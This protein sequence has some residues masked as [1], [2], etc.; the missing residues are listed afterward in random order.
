MWFESSVRWRARLTLRALRA[1][2]RDVRRA[3]DRWLLRHVSEN[4]RSQFGLAHQFA[5][6]GSAADFQRDVPVRAMAEVERATA[7][8]KRGTSRALTERPPVCLAVSEEGEI[9]L[10]AESR[11][12]GAQ[13]WRLWAA[14]MERAHPGALAGHHAV[15]PEDTPGRHLRA[16]GIRVLAGEFAVPWTPRGKRAVPARVAG[17]RDATLRMFLAARFALARDVTLLSARGAADLAAFGKLIQ[18][19]APSLIRAIRDGGLGVFACEQPVLCKSLMRGLQPDP[20]RARALDR[21]AERLGRLR[22][23]DAWPRLK[24]LAIRSGAHPKGALWPWYG[25]RPVVETGLFVGPERVALPILGLDGPCAL[26][27]PGLTEFLAPAGVVPLR[28]HELREGEPYQVVVTTPGG[29]Y[30]AAT[31]LWVRA[32]GHRDGAVLVEPVDPPMARR[33]APPHLAC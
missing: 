29:L 13:L 12:A 24:A 11:R 23:I 33:C 6:I 1:T 27:S 8:L 25:S 30:R 22:P 2:W 18:D 7:E 26:T 15:V 3:E 16:R 4:A 9:P 14:E 17:L 10:A 31:S 19:H 32:A 28:Q 20:E 21:A 5:Q